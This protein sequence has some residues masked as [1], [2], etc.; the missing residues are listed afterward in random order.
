M[1]RAKK[2]TLQ[3]AAAEAWRLGLLP[4]DL[5]ALASDRR[6]DLLEL[7]ARTAWRPSRSAV[8][9]GASELRA[10]HS[11]IERAAPAFRVDR[12]LSIRARALWRDAEQLEAV[13]ASHDQQ[14][15]GYTTART[16]NDVADAYLV[17]ADAFLEAGSHDR[18][19]QMQKHAEL[20]RRQAERA[21]VRTPDK[22]QR[23]PREVEAL[24]EIARAQGWRIERTR[25]GHWRFV[26]PDPTRD[27]V[28]MSG[29]AS[30]WR[31]VRNFRAAL[32][33]SGLVF[34]AVGRRAVRT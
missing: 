28:V 22:I 26:P 18:A 2:L 16:Y 13:R 7:R 1:T 14:T 12:E 27:I 24:A 15:V 29:T 17:A 10:F 32:R 6:G 11:A 25:G 19:Y 4:S 8:A 34:G 3:E 5:H 31:A 21:E 33:R 23:D 30:D 20:F 9:R